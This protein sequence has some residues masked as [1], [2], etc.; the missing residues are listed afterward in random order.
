MTEPS[1]LSLTPRVEPDQRL[2]QL[3]QEGQRPDVGQFLA[4]SGYLSPA[5]VLA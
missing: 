5:Q 3:W 4:D 1:S 2:Q